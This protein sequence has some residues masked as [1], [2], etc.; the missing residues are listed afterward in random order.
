MLVAYHIGIRVFLIQATFAARLRYLLGD[1][2]KALKGLEKS[3]LVT[4]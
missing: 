3:K 1:A 2:R 4:H